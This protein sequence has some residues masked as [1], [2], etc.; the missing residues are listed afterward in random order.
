MNC[1]A[2]SDNTTDSGMQLYRLQAEIGRPEE[3]ELER[4]WCVIP[5]TFTEEGQLRVLFAYSQK[6]LGHGRSILGETPFTPPP[7]PRGCPLFH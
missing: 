6:K 5:Y 1:I 3:E 2:Q 7:P 4:R